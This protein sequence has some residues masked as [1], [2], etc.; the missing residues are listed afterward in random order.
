MTFWLFGFVL[1]TLLALLPFAIAFF[2]EQKG[3]AILMFLFW[4]AY[5]FAVLL[6]T[7]RA[8]NRYSGPKFWAYLAQATVVY[9]WF[10][11]ALSFV[12]LI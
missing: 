7:W 3:F 11:F 1:A 10:Q 6:G 8:A 2:S 5:E 4:L 9:G 12:L